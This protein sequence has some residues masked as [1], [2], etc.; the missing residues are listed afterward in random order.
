MTKRIYV[1]VALL[2]GV[3]VTPLRAQVASNDSLAARLRRAEAAIAT[4]QK[5]IGEQSESGVKARSG[6]SVEIHGRVLMNGFLNTSRV[7]NVDNPQFVR[8]DSAAGFPMRGIGMAVRQTQ[9]GVVVRVPD[10]LYGKFDGDLDVDFSGGQMPSGGGRT[11]PLMRLRTARAFL[12]W[13]QSEIM[14]GQESPLISGLNPIAPSSANTPGF[15]AAGNLWLWLPQARISAWTQGDVSY[16]IEGAIL[17]PTSGDP[18]ATFETD[19]DLAERSAR[20]YL[21]SR[22][23]MKWGEADLAGELGC[24][25]HVGWLVPVASRVTSWAVACDA[26][27]PVLPWLEFR[28]EYFNGQS[29]RGLGGGGIGQNFTPA[30]RPLESKGGWAQVNVK[31]TFNV[32]LGVGCSADHPEPGVT[33]TRNDA[34]AAYTMY[35]PVAPLFIGAEIRRLRTEWAPGRFTNDHVTLAA[36]FEF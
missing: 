19:N 36:G 30:N 2:A 28:G 18:S 4:L 13:G 7:N 1:A 22:V 14:I 16:G 23:F 27:L 20:P 35:R 21:Q 10:V 9:L 25:G 29:L 15:A 8:P 5:Q 17:A 34:C 33:R 32:R 12:R 26:L 31:P 24:G 3:L 11:F 6:A